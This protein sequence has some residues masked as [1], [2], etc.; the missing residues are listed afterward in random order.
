MDAHQA[1]A[2][3]HQVGAE[4]HQARAEAHQSDV[5]TSKDGTDLSLQAAVAEFQQGFDNELAHLN[6]KVDRITVIRETDD[7]DDQ[8]KERE[9]QQAP[10]SVTAP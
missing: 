8:T 2:G 10:N 7:D 4:A 6:C 1:G 5:D 9:I 3:D